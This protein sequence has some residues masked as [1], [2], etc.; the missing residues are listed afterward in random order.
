[1]GKIKYQFVRNSLTTLV[2]VFFK[3]TCFQRPFVG[4][5][6]DFRR[7]YVMM[8]FFINTGVSNLFAR[9]EQVSSDVYFLSNESPNTP[10]VSV[11]FLRWPLPRHGNLQGNLTIEEPCSY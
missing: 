11:A 5:I 9:S 10:L 1:M 7:I 3:L 2:N 4:S 8:V 6:L